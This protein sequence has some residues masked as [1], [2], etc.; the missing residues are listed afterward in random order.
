MN[1]NTPPS[2][3]ATAGAYFSQPDECF[4][5]EGEVKEHWKRLLRNVENLSTAELK[6]R[7][8]EVL[9]LLQENGVTYNVYGESGGLNRPWLLDTIPLLLGDDEWNL[10][11]KGMKQRAY[12]LNK[13][14]EDLY[15]ERKLLKEG[16]IPPELIY[17]HSGFLRPCDGIKLPGPHQ[18]LLYAADLSRGPDGKIWVLRDRTQAPSGVGYAL[19][20]RSALSRVL[21]ELFR[22]HHVTKL[23]GFFNSMM[24]S[25][26]KVAPQG[27][28]QPRIVLLTPGP[29]NE[30]YFEHAFLASYLGFTLAQGDDMLVRDG[31]VWIKTVEGLEKVDIILRRVDD[32]YCDPLELREDSQL[33]IPGLLEVVRKG[34]VVIVNP[35]GSSL[36]ENTGLMAFMHA[37]FH[38]FVKEDPIF[39]MVATWW[40]GQKKEMEY[41]IAHIDDLVIKKID[42]TTGS[43]TIVGNQLTR[44]QKE[45]II[46]KIR[47]QPYLYVGQ[48]AVNLSTSPVFTNDKLEPRYTVIRTFLVASENDYE[49]M[50]G[51]LTRC[52]PEKGSL[53]VSNQEGGISKDTWVEIPQKKFPAVIEN[54]NVKR[55]DVLPSRAAENL[56]WVGRYIQRVVRTSRFIRI[57]LRNLNQTGYLN[58]DQESH[59]LGELMRT[60]NLL[61]GT[62]IVEEEADVT[63]EKRLMEIHQMICN[64]EMTGSILFNANNLLKAMYAVRDKWTV[65]NWRIIDDIENVKRRLAV[66]EPENIRH[67][68]SLLDQLNMGLL[69][70]LEMNRQSMYRGEGWVMYRIGQLIEE[71]TLELTQYRSLLTIPYEE[72]AEF[73]VLEAL[74]VS[75]QNL[76]NYRSVYRTYFEIAPA[77]D[78]LLLNRQNPISVLSQLEHL[79]KYLEQLPQSKT[80][81]PENSLVNLA[82]ECYSK[83]RLASIE[84]LIKGEKET[85]IRMALDALC[86][87][88]TFK[89]GE[90]S[91]KLSASYFSHSTYQQQGSKD[92]FQFEV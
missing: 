18:L 87:E 70:F 31:C 53:I 39:P 40:C 9:K 47:T 71:L 4:G 42:R 81:T 44:A 10:V 48:E 50:P 28:E 41:V 34:N 51:G 19:E 69:S 46:R 29:R 67:V 80:G 27:K 49:I 60:M 5:P 75:N 45:E 57:V 88:L 25:F 65:D 26:I 55:N 23:G 33:G 79:V 62:K 64:P 82:F 16:I 89:I 58:P 74:L 73:Q 91:L 63:S 68:F 83:V 20:N 54:A 8:L 92:N 43:E 61:T 12:V 2:L 32:S 35:L 24:Q 56:F 7:Q 22:D 15:G 84:A 11:E 90:L 52:S 77:L 21:P 6:N 14:L 30:T 17:A 13:I 37:I 38:Y 86:G 76:S 3:S 78:L 66:L 85:G 59:A 1:T 36:L 72:N